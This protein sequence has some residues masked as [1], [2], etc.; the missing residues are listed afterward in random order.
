MD[1]GF[2]PREKAIEAVRLLYY[3]NMDLVIGT[4]AL[5]IYDTRPVAPMVSTHLQVGLHRMMISHLIISLDKCREFYEAYKP[6][7]PDEVREAWQSLHRE[8]F[9]RGITGFRNTVVGHI[10]DKKTGPPRTG[11]EVDRRL[12]QVLRN[13]TEVFLRWINNPADNSFPVTVVSTTDR[14]RLSVVE[15]YGLQG[16]HESSA[17]ASA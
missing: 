16:L 4:Q 8:I 5:R 3:L 9:E 10:R 1:C 6:I 7:L 17:G 13:D 14:T 2:D 15:R 12:G 11:D